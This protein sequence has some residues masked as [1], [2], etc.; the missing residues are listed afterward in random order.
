[1]SLTFLADEA[2][3]PL[4][5][6]E[7]W[8]GFEP[9]A[10]RVR[11]DRTDHCECA[12]ILPSHYHHGPIT[13]IGSWTAEVNHITDFWLSQIPVAVSRPPLFSLHTYSAPSFGLPMYLLLYGFW[14]NGSF[15]GPESFSLR[16]YLSRPS[17]VL[18]TVVMA[19]FIPIM[20]LVTNLYIFLNNFL[21]IFNFL[22]QVAIQF[23][24]IDF[25]RT[26]EI[27]YWCWV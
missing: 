7:T 18:W 5:F 25:G 19:S 4:V 3:C 20:T 14:R 16:T 26:I 2:R 23:H 8:E 10:P 17:I 22:I 6:S 24:L 12:C 13:L 9:T 1:M 21:S 15:T 27:V 11:C